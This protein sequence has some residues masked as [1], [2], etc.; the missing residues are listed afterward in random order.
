ML[1]H[2]VNRPLSL[3]RCPDGQTGQC[4]FQKHAA[5]GTPATLGRVMITEKKG[6]GEYLYVRNIDGLVSLAQISALEIH[7]WGSLRDKVDRPDRVI[8]DLDP[9]PH[10]TWP[11]IVEAAIRI[12][13]LLAARD[14]QS[15]EKN[16]RGKGLHV[17][18]PVSPRRRDWDEVK[19]FSKQLS[20]ELAALEPHAYTTNMSKAARKGKIFIDYLRN[21]AGSTAIAPYS[22]RAKPNATVAMPVEWK[23]L[24]SVRSDQF[25]VGNAVRHIEGRQRDPWQGMPEI[26]QSF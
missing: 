16:T 3:V 22:T 15:D 2:I 11:R 26:S 6:E 12:R 8:F 5:A 9:D 20:E 25:H 10:V 21:D 13:D 14:L 19:T 1:P 7:L 24:P 17:V 23:D 4:F 18:V